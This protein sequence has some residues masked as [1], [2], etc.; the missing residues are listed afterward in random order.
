MKIN[1]EHP[2]K[3]SRIAMRSLL[4]ANK[5]GVILLLSSM[6]GLQGAYSCP[7]YVASKH[8]VVGFAKSMAQADVDQNVK[9]VCVCPGIVDTPLWTG[10]AAKEYTITMASHKNE[11]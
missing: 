6:A 2:L 1:A 9:V 8:A 7:L 4:G 11:V 10:D 5:P 3:L